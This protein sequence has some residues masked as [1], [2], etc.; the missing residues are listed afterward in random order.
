M[1]VQNLFVQTCQVMI[2]VVELYVITWT[3]ATSQNGVLLFYSLA[4]F[5]VLTVLV[6]AG[7]QSGRISTFLPNYSKAILSAKRIFKVLDTAPEIDNYSTEGLEPVSE[8]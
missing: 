1:S 2:L 4:V 3:W 8:K 5:R 7:I 6:M